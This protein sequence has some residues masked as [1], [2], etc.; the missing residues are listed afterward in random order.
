MLRIG[1]HYSPDGTVDITPERLR[2]WANQFQRLKE[3]RQVVPMDWDHADDARKAIPLSTDKWAKRR[4]AKNTVGVLRDFKVNEDG[5]SATLTMN[6]KN[7]AKESFDDNHVFVSPVIFDSWQDGQG[8]QYEDVITHVD[9]V[10]HPVDA[11]QGPFEPCEPGA[12]ACAL[13]MGLQAGS[14]KTYRLGPLPTGDEMDDEK[15]EDEDLELEDEFED[16]DEEMDESESM[17]YEDDEDLDDDGVVEMGEDELFDDGDELDVVVE[18]VEDPLVIELKKSIPAVLSELGL[19]SPEGVD[20]IDD[21]VRFWEQQVA[22]MKQKSLDDA[23][24]VEDDFGM[25]DD[26]GDLDFGDDEEMSDEETDNEDLEVKDPQMAAMSLR[27]KDSDRKTAALEARLIANE[28]KDKLRRLSLCQETGRITPAIFNELK[29]D[30]TATRMSL[31][32]D[33]N[34]K[35][36]DFD[37]KLELYESLPEGVLLTAKEKR[38]SLARKVERPRDEGDELTPEAAKKINDELFTRHP[39]RGA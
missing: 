8:N 23:G 30:L 27:L 2:H 35:K 37:T 7:S 38:L 12:V 6:V 21:P 19:V 28:K 10:N 16:D 4:S 1:T 22:A 13:R 5:K 25:D 34:T 24:G 31:G 18:E 20:P 11:S 39:N 26:F 32:D 15:L 3:N 29:K 36:T 9:V 14:P 33:G 17:D